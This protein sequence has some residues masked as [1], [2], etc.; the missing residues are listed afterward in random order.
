M[1]LHRVLKKSILMSAHFTQASTDLHNNARDAHTD[2][3]PSL[4]STDQ[5]RGRED[6]S[7]SYWVFHICLNLPKIRFSKASWPAICRL[8]SDYSYLDTVT[9]G[10]CSESFTHHQMIWSE[11]R[12]I[13]VYIQNNISAN[14]YNSSTLRA[15][16]IKRSCRVSI[17]M[18]RF[19][20]ECRFL[21]EI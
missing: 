16:F 6:S 4:L 13:T 18:I 10:R 8:H 14:I 20:T 15:K 21:N 12:G 3:T 7:P 5:S 17:L 19:D 11:W 2:Q 9:P 1:V